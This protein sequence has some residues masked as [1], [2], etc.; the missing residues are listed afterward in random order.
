MQSFEGSTIIFEG[1]GLRQ[2]LELETRTRTRKKC[3]VEIL[4]KDVYGGK[5]HTPSAVGYP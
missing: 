2:E 5:T 3:A 1:D 4:E